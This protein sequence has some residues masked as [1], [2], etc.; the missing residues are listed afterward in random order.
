MLSEALGDLNHL[1]AKAEEMVKLAKRFHE[2]M[3][4]R[5]NSSDMMD[6]DLA[7]ELADLGISSPVTREV[8][9]RL[10][11]KE[12]SQQLVEFLHRSSIVNSAGG[13]VPLTEA[14]RLFCRARYTH[15]ISPEDFLQAAKLLSEV[16]S[17]LR[18]REF[19]SGA[20]VISS[21]GQDEDAIILKILN[22]A[23]QGAADVG[24]I[25]ARESEIASS[26]TLWAPK[27]GPG[28]SRASISAAL[29]ISLVAAGEL[30][31]VT[32]AKGHLCRDDGPEG[33]RWYAN[34]FDR[35]SP[36]NVQ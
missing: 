2:K 30:L 16:D 21:D 23:K 3:K 1:M 35:F 26:G 14:Y 13:L 18:L 29:Q 5:T 4:V 34:F 17:R 9:G 15:L 25:D 6:S 20:K 27:L 24:D 32:E 11:F 7:I 22:L 33:V 12:L 31:R 8:A 10:Y 28:V 36:L 19:P